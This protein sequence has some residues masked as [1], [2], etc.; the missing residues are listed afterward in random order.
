MGSC[1]LGRAA[2]GYAPMAAVRPRV[3]VCE[4]DR[5]TAD[6]LVEVLRDEGYAT[7]LATTQAAALAALGRER[8]AAIVA[9]CLSPVTRG[10]DA[11]AVGAL[12]RAAAPAPV[13]L[14]TA[15]WPAG[16][17]DPVAW[18]V[19]AMVPKPFDVE[20]LL[21]AVRDAAAPPPAV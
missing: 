19:A 21:A 17:A 8:F 18:G 6:L 16:R 15:R 12:V 14:C 13:V 9:D 4:D 11:A 10:L 5:A 7:E 3:L 1:A 2:V 20:E